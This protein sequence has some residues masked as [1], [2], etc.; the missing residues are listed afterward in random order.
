M[1]PV[2]PSASEQDEQTPLILPTPHSR[3]PHF[4]TAPLTSLPTI[5]VPKLRNGYTIVNL[6]CAIVFLAAS[7]APF[8]NIPFTRLIEDA[9]CRQYY[10][11]AASEPVDEE[12]CKEP[13]IQGQVAFTFGILR[14]LE[15]IVSILAALPW[16]IA[17]DRY[18]TLV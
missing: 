9:V 11:H 5:N 16:G 15:S 14:M 6:L 17:A 8:A 12:M 10:Q 4:R 7:S 18:I 13:Q 1:D 2:N 3:P